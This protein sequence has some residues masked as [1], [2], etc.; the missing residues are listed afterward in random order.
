MRSYVR[1]HQRYALAGGRG[2]KQLYLYEPNDPVSAIW[3]KLQ[4]A[5]RQPHPVPESKAREALHEASAY[6]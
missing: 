1:K 2:R 5:N 4:V 3:A 6:R